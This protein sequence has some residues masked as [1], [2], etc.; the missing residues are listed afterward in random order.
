ML[1]VNVKDTIGMTQIRFTKESN[2]LLRQEG[3]ATSDA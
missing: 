2:Q 3:C 1:E